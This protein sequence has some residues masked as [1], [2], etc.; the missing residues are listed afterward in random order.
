ME[1]MPGMAGPPPQAANQITPENL[2][3]FEQMREEIPPSEFSEDLLSTASEA[4][5][6]QSD[7]RRDSG[8][9]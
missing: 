4:G 7:G 8:V 1:H 9:S 3:V 6:Y 5:R 2:A